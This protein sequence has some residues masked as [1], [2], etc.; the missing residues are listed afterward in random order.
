MKI[1]ELI[2]SDWWL[3]LDLTNLEREL[4]IENLLD[5]KKYD[6]LICENL[7]I[8]TESLDKLNSVVASIKQKVPIAYLIEQFPFWGLKLK[9]TPAVLIPRFDTEVLVQTVLNHGSEKK[10]SIVDIGTGS[11]AIALALSKM[12]PNW[13][14]WATDVSPKAIEVA[15]ENGSNLNLKVNWIITDLLTG[16]CKKF[17]LLVTNPPY[18]KSNGQNLCQ[19]VL[20]HEPA[21]ALYGGPDGLR[22]IDRILKSCK[23]NLKVGSFIC[24]EHGFDQADKIFQL[25]KQLGYQFVEKINDLAGHPRVSVLKWEG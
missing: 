19:S 8:K 5:I 7:E 20:S 13:E 21:L 4:I 24:I 18:V 17:D 23:K 15:T 6:R 10:M 11:G 9:V 1:G 14:I 3:E 16:I 2:R 12:R 25:S 22:V